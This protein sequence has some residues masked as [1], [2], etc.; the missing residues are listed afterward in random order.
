MI[1]SRWRQNFSN[2]KDWCLKRKVSKS[3]WLY[4]AMALA[5]AL[6][7]W[8]SHCE[9][10]NMVQTFSLWL[11]SCFAWKGA[12]AA[13]AK[14]LSGMTKGGHE[15]SHLEITSCWSLLW[16]PKNRHL[17]LSFTFIYQGFTFALLHHSLPNRTCQS[18]NCS[19]D[20]AAQEGSPC[21]RHQR[22]IEAE[23]LTC[24]ER[25]AAHCVLRR[26]KS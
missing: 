12:A 1:E 24:V 9:G 17:H 3:S 21:Q 22:A 16:L 10:A 26:Q 15:T 14:F 4:L 25:N 7:M 2:V 20:S 11:G 8:G 19:P 13:E 6:A 18:L 23:G 5:M